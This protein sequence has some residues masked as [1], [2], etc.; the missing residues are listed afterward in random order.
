MDMLLVAN[1]STLGGTALVDLGERRLVQIL[2][3]HGGLNTLEF[4][5][6]LGWGVS[7]S[8][9]KTKARGTSGLEKKSTPLPIWVRF[10]PDDTPHGLKASPVVLDSP[11]HWAMPVDRA[12][13]PLVY[14]N[15]GE[16][17]EEWLIIEVVSAEVKSRVNAHGRVGRSTR[18]R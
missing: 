6:S 8:A 16:N 17:A 12:A 18:T 1:A 15:T 5:P 11:V 7:A 3:T 9:G 14:L 10:A 2:P 4:L 13:S